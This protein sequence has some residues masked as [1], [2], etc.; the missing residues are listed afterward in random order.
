MQR[1]VSRY[2]A[3][4]MVLLAV[5][6]CRSMTG[7]S[8][9][10]NID[11]STTTA[12]VK[13]KLTG[14][15]LHNLTWVH[16]DTNA[17]V[18]SLTGTAPTQEQKD[19]AAEIAATVPAVKGV[20]NNIQFKSASAASSTQPPMPAASPVTSPGHH[21]VTGDV[22]SVDYATGQ[23]GLQSGMQAMMLR[24]PPAAVAGVRQGDRVTLDVD[25]RP[26]Q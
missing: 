25:I 19:R 13:T 12:E 10:T 26:A 14:E 18:V 11:D 17:G 4:A 5:A 2:L 16:V 7:Q 1:M 6:G 23:L 15:K 22:L 20:V 9:G 8:L 3:V 24:L 21:T